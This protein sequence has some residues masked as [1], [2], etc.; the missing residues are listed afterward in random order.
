MQII[1]L[2]EYE[3]LSNLNMNYYLT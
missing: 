1:I 2:L 3:L